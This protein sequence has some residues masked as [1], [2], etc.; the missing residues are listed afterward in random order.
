MPGALPRFFFFLG[1]A[2]K[3]ELLSPVSKT[4]STL[5][6]KQ[7]TEQVM[8][9]QGCKLRFIPFVMGEVARVQ[10]FLTHHVT[11]DTLPEI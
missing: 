3:L 8:L 4:N 2:G 1:G 5:S 10:P 7:H 11:L 9:K 6:E